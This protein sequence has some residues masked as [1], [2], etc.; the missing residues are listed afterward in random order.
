M[1][2]SLGLLFSLL[3]VCNAFAETADDEAKMVFQLNE[4]HGIWYNDSSPKIEGSQNYIYFSLAYRNP[5]YGVTLLGSHADTTYIYNGG[6]PNNF[7]LTTILD[8]TISGFYKF[9]NIKGLGVRA[10]LDINLPT[11]THGFSNKELSTLFLDR[12]TQDLNIVTSFG[13]G[14]DFAPNLVTTKALSKVTVGLGVRYEMQGEYDPT[15]DIAGDDYDPG[16][17]LMLIGTGLYRPDEEG[18]ILMVDIASVMSTRDRQGGKDVFKQGA[19]NSLEVRYIKK[20]ELFRATYFASYSIQEKNQILSGGG[21][22]T[23]EDR[24]SNSNLYQFFVNLSYPMS[25][26]INVNGIVGYKMV[27]A[28]GYSAGHTLYDGGYTKLN[29]GGGASFILSDRFF[30]TADMRFYQISNEADALEPAT[31]AYNGINVDIGFVYTF[32][33][34]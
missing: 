31:A 10:G 32:S 4:N 13:K 11:G 26:R 17:L 9:E 28:N 19:V 16:D 8:T 23:S 30:W 15:K 14:L 18:S 20:Y 1:R 25:N 3:L 21:G 33:P 6:R 7:H 12:V 34:H 29:M 27:M 24:N 2:G 5:G 22:V